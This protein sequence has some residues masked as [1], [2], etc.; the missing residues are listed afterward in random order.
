MFHRYNKNLID[1]RDQ[2]R[3]IYKEDKLKP[4]KK[5]DQKKFFRKA[6]ARLRSI[7]KFAQVA[8]TSLLQDSNSIPSIIFGVTMISEIFLFL[9]YWSSII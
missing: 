8:T 2:I 6:W 5:E 3:A 4:P 1:V 9:H 7:R